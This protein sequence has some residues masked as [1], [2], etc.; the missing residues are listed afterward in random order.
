MR[1]H[2]TTIASQEKN[3]RSQ[4]DRSFH[5]FDPLVG[6][7]GVARWQLSFAGGKVFAWLSPGLQL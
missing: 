4:S 7:G 6:G 1:Q 5:G 3:S 2:F